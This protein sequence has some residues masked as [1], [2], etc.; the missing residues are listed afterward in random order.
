MNRIKSIIT[1]IIGLA[2]LA[3]IFNRN[4]TAGHVTGAHP[5]APAHLNKP[6][7]KRG[8][9]TGIKSVASSNNTRFGAGLKEHFDRTR[10]ARS[11]SSAKKVAA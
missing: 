4:V 2:G 11:L 5:S 6:S 9:R 8:Y 3:T 1:S 10:K 7:H